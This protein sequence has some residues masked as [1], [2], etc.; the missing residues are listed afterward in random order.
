MKTNPGS[1]FVYTV[2]DTEGRFLMKGT[3]EEIQEQLGI[4]AKYVGTYYNV[5]RVI[6][7]KYVVTRNEK[8]ELVLDYLKRH[9]EEYGNTVLSGMTKKKAEGYLTR[10][11]NREGIRAKLRT[12][13]HEEDRSAWYVVEV[14]KECTD[15]KTATDPTRE[16]KRSSRTRKKD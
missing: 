12:V 3:A 8:E 16:S 10:L 4:P 11:Y 7:K 9:L 15:S 6:Y 2:R 14:V 1:E 13:R 5:N